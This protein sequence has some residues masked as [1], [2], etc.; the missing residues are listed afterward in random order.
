[1][2]RKFEGA[3]NEKRNEENCEFDIYFNYRE[4]LYCLWL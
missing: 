4:I 3:P 2:C 1:M